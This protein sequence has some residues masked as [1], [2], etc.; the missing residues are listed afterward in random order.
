M[1][2]QVA[3]YLVD[4]IDRT[5]TATVSTHTFT[6]DRAHYEIDLSDAN[7]NLL[8]KTMATWTQ[9]A[10]RI[11]TPPNKRRSRYISNGPVVDDPAAARKW[12]KEHGYSVSQQGRLPIEVA[13]AYLRE[14]TPDSSL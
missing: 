8:R 7:A 6:L 9:R 10:R 4:D 3:V 13:E 1:A 2:K 14:A 11:K 5:T 12:A